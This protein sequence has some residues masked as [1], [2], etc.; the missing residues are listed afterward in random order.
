V[1]ENPAPDV[2]AANPARAAFHGLL[3]LLREAADDWLVPGRAADTPEDVVEGLRNVLHLL[4]AGIDFYLEGDAEHPA[5]V[6]IVSPIRRFMGDNPDA[7]YHLSRIRGDRGYRIRGKRGAATYISLTVH[8]RA[9]DGRLGATAEPV[10]ADVND[11]GFELE[12]DGSFEVILSAVKPAGQPRNWIELP[13]SAASVVARHYFEEPG[14]PAVERAG[15]IELSIEALEPAPPRERPG[16]EEFATRLDDVA[17]FVRGGTVEG[18]EMPNPPPFVSTTPNELGEPMVFRVAGTDAWGAVDIAYSMG[19]FELGEGEALLI[20][21][22]FPA[23]AFA[24]VVLWN[25]FMQCFEYRDR[26]VSLNRVQTRLEDDGSYRIVLS[27]RDPGAGNWLDTEGRRTGTIFWRF[28]LPE[29]TPE[30]P[31]CRVVRQADLEAELGG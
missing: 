15:A 31:R 4:S 26:R 6:P 10:L 8:G 24:N 23:C 12:A 18:L 25:R 1:S 9:E 14:T 27:D 20:E 30:R 5:F 2:S 19:P 17:A 11:R 28:L 13:A 7:I 3:D 21:G 22:R 29:T 16:P